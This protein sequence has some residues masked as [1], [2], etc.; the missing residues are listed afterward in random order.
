[1]LRPYQNDIYH[2]VVGLIRKGRRRI[3]ITVCTGAGKTV[4]ASHF[5]KN[6]FNKGNSAL[7]NVHR[8]ELI[9]QSAATFVRDQF[10]FGIIAPG[11]DEEY[12][13]AIQVASIMT[14]GRRMQKLGKRPNVIIWDECFVAGTLIDGKPIEKMKIGDEVECLD[15]YNFKYSKNKITKL[16]KK[17]APNTL[18][19]IK[20]GDKTLITTFNHPIYVK[21]IGWTTA[22]R[23]K[24]GDILYEMRRL[25]K[26]TQQGCKKSLSNMLSE[27]HDQEKFYGEKHSENDSKKSNESAGD[28][29]KSIKYFKKN[30]PQTDNSGWKWKTIAT[31]SNRFAQNS[32][33]SLGNR[34][35]GLYKYLSRIWT[36][37]KL[38]NRYSESKDENSNRDR[39]QFPLFVVSTGARFKKRELLKESR[40]ESVEIFKRGIDKQYEQVCGDGFVYN[41]EVEQAHTYFANDIFVHNCHH[42][43]ADNWSRIFHHFPDA[44]HIGLTATPERLDGKGLGDYF[45]EMILGPSMADLISDGYLTGY[46]L[47]STAEKI[48]ISKIG[49]RMGDYISTDLALEVNTPRIRGN[50]LEQWKKHALNKKTLIFSQ[51]VAHSIEM[52]ETFMNAGF[53]AEHI[54]GG[55][56]KG[57]RTAAL[58]RYKNSEIDLLSNVDLFGEGFDV[59]ATQAIIKLQKTL[60][61]SKDLQVS[62]R[63]LR[64]I[65]HPRYTRE[66]L[67]DRS[68]RLQA[69]ADSDK[70]Y[71][72]IIDQVGNWLTHGF[73]DDERVWS[74]A[75]RNKNE[76]RAI[77][78]KEC[79]K[80]Y[81]VEKGYVR[82]CS[83][84]GHIFVQAAVREIDLT[85]T[86]EELVEIDVE[87][88]KL[89][90]KRQQ[91]VARTEPE[92]VALAK[93]RGSTARNAALFAKY[94]L[95]GR[96]RK[97]Q[98]Q[99][100]NNGR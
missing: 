12:Q 83:N 58:E 43:A 55:S 45:E 72:I 96:E 6:C 20:I 19:K 68:C 8:V 78:A 25:P 98:K 1:M 35:I 90:K 44:I 29:S 21:N 17:P 76:E 92:L 94:V 5:L 57:H 60:S 74:L 31:A 49:K 39:W 71:G 59:P 93:S 3:L 9:K 26:D 84:C 42:L 32:W 40:V 81:E 73:C 79:P 67:L 100:G 50:T 38:Q 33:A 87:K 4:L 62:G 97:K 51:N 82:K 36:I 63:V 46:R 75:G 7:F 95:A 47:K 70:P 11:F 24:K 64:P 22:S 2:Q 54:D 91:A 30:R 89:E 27:R 66:D 52:T 23:I 34:T 69:I 15:E 13:K 77:T 14:L 88:M 86:D 80:C 16:F 61:L 53:A 65:Y 85:S 41:I 10:P 48:D 99:D 56:D 28:K 18:Y 37:D